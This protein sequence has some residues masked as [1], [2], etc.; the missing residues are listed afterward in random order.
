MICLLTFRMPPEQ[1]MAA[2]QRLQARSS[3]SVASQPCVSLKDSLLSGFFSNNKKYPPSAG[4]IGVR[5]KAPMQID[6]LISLMSASVRS[7]TNNRAL[8]KDDGGAASRRIQDLIVAICLSFIARVL[9][10]SSIHS[11]C[12][13]AA[14]VAYAR[15]CSNQA[16][17]PHGRDP[18]HRDPTPS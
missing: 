17:S 12:L 10:V 2:G 6:S 3:P 14:Q 5:E 9:C 18:G 1:E 4:C 13:Y 7:G 15:C 8:N 16:C 11:F